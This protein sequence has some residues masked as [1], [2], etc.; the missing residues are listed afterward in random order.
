MFERIGFG[1]TMMDE[2]AGGGGA[3]DG[4]NEHASLQFETWVAGQPDEVK[5]MLESHTGGLKSALQSERERAKGL[6]KGLREAASKAEKGSEN[7]K[8]LVALADQVQEAS[9]K[10]AF[11]ENAVSAGA[12]NLKLAY[13]AAVSD[14]LFKRDGS[15][16][17]EALKK[18]Y[19]ELFG[20]T[21]TNNAGSGGKGPD[22]KITMDDFIR[23]KAGM[24]TL[25]GG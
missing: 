1:R 19:P 10:N 17:F 3:G 13:M 22:K 14:D 6:E 5:A 9:R 23:A 18:N 7:E 15:V 11:Y 12:T 2:G 21:S 16:D 8:Q 24:N 25:N 20:K 4:S